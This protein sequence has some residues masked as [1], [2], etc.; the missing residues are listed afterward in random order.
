MSEC[1]EN[2]KTK[3][4][5]WCKKSTSDLSDGFGKWCLGVRKA[6]KFFQGIMVNVL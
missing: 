6:D 1:D 5:A 2:E 3:A 4:V